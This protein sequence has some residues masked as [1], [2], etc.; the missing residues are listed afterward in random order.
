MTVRARLATAARAAIAD[1]V[2][3]YAVGSTVNGCGTFRSDMD[4]SV[5]TIT[6][7]TED[8]SIRETKK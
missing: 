3:V 8:L 2:D 7:K 4:L 1:C 5:I 6:T